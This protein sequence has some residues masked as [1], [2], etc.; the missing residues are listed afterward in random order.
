MGRRKSN[1]GNDSDLSTRSLVKN[2]TA[3]GLHGAESRTPENNVAG[4]R[5]NDHHLTG[6]LLLKRLIPPT[7]SDQGIE[8]E[9]IQ[10]IDRA[11]GQTGR[12]KFLC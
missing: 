5:R 8:A 12:L 2:P 9:Y 3:Q 11:T 7:P 10:K 1:P 4:K 6:T